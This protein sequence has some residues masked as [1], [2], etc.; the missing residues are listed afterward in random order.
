MF[1][2][3]PLVEFE[4]V[5]M[6]YDT[7]KNPTLQNVT[8]KIG[9]GEFYFLTGASGSGK[10]TILKLIRMALRQSNGTISIDGNN[11]KYIKQ[12]DIPIYRRKIG[13]VFQDFNLINHLSVFDNL[14]MP[15]R[16][17]NVSEEE[18]RDRIESVS[19]WIGLKGL[20]K[21]IVATL[22]GG[23]QQLTAVARAIITQPDLVIADEPTASIDPKAEAKVMH[24][25]TELNSVGM[26]FLIATHNHTLVERMGRKR[27]I[28]E[29][30]V[31]R[32]Y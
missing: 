2:N 28:L 20:D 11:T 5:G 7:N 17:Q 32:Q 24:L 25:L 15:L 22:S 29:D 23:Q 14:M 12:D 6:Q 10:S 26:A 19:A 31:V 3:R 8:F 21:N 27:L 13:V 16:L 1:F 4:N 9:S 30:G 18:A